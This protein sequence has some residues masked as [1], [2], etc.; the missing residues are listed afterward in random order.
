M[1]K[2]ELMA[3]AGDWGALHSAV[4]AGADAVYFGIKGINMRHGASNFDMLEIKK[5]MDFF[6]QDLILYKTSL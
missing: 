6:Y 3:P 1:K 5:I 2:P 4:D